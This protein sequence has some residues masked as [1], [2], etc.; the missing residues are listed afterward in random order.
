MQVVEAGNL[1][2]VHG[3]LKPNDPFVVLTA[4]GGH[5]FRT[6]TLREG[7][8]APDWSLGEDVEDAAG[9]Q[10]TLSLMVHDS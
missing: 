6:S 9:A 8:V 10:A 2:K 1:R 3:V 7:G 4:P 5:S